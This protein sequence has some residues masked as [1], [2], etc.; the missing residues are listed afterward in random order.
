MK[1]FIVNKMITF[2]NQLNYKIK[3]LLDKNQKKR[4]IKNITSKSGLTMFAMVSQII[5]P[6][7]MIMTWGLNS[8]GTWVFLIAIMQGATIFNINISGPVTNRMAILFNQKKL[9]DINKIY[10]NFFIIIILNILIYT[11]FF[12]IFNFIDKLDFKIFENIKSDEL[13]LSILILFISFILNIYNNLF[14][15][16][17][18]YTGKQYLNDNITM[19]F[20]LILKFFLIISGIFYNDFIILTLIFLIINLIKTAAYHII[21]KK[22]NAVIKFEYFNV[23]RLFAIIRES[24]GNIIETISHTLKNNFQIIL[25]GIFL[26]AP[27]VAIISTYKTLFYFFPIRLLDI[28]SQTTNYE[29]INFYTK[30]QFTKLRYNLISLLNLNFILSFFILIIGISLGPLFYKYW[31]KEIKDPNLLIIFFLIIDCIFVNLSNTIIVI[32][33]SLNKYFKISLIILIS[34]AISTLMGYMI[35]SQSYNYINFFMLNAFVS[36]IIFFLFLL[37][38]AEFN[39]IIKIKKS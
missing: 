7:L 15:T 24:A 31:I 37:F 34:Y 35:L 16:K 6:P 20:D 12:L 25:L 26:N 13:K 2:F 1:I 9:N 23:K 14:I 29:I 19:C 33:K 5:F 36:I 22:F 28:I 3:F 4:V 30:K 18:G 10:S 38:S 11:T 17:I 27:T 39:K 8:F 32:E 21:S